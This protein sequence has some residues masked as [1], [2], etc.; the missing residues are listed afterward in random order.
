MGAS[1]RFDPQTE[2]NISLHALGEPWESFEMGRTVMGQPG[3]RMALARRESFSH[4]G[5]EGLRLFFRDEATGLEA[6]S[7]FLF[8]G[9]NPVS[10][11]RVTVR[12][13]GT[14]PIGLD[15]LHGAYIRNLEWRRPDQF[16]LH[17]PCNHSYAENQWRDYSLPDLGVVRTLR[18]RASHH[19]V[20][21]LGRS[22]QVRVPM[23]LLEDRLRG[24]TWVWQIEHPGA[25]L[26]EVGEED[27]SLS[28]ALGGLDEAHLH[29]FKTLQPGEE[30]ESLSVAAGAV[31]GDAERALDALVDFR[32]AACRSPHPV[33][34]GLPVVFNDYMNCLMGHVT[35]EKSLRLIPRAAEA[36]CE[37]YT[38]D[39]GWFGARGWNDVG[40]WH[41]NPG[42]FPGGLNRVMD[43]I[44]ER[45]MIPGLWLEIEAAARHV[46]LAAKPD[47]W[48]IF[49]RG[50]RHAHGDR[51]ALDFRNA[52]VRC[53]AD[54]TVDRLVHA[55]DLGYLKMDYNLT[56]G[57]GP[58]TRTDSP[59]AGAVDHLRAV[60]DWFRGVRA[61][62]PRVIIENCASGGMRNDYGMLSILQM[63]S[64]SDQ[65]DRKAYPPLVVG[66]LATLLPEQLGVWSY[67][68]AGEDREAA[69]FNMV[70]AMLGRIHQSGQIADID[71]SQFEAVREGIALYKSSLRRDI[72]RSHPFW[73]LG[74]V[75]CDQTES[76]QAAG[77]A[78]A[79]D[80]RAWL[81]VW[82]MAGPEAE[83][84]LPLERLPF[85]PSSVEQV[86]PASPRRPHLL[87]SG[88]LRATLPACHSAVL[89]G[90][91][92]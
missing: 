82:R 72:P 10:R 52:E 84:E 29:W 83:I 31:P 59:G 78:T 63:A 92:A 87:R 69:V 39:A 67:P 89:F 14:Q 49:R 40:D 88:V 47:D 45:G 19:L 20:S 6:T 26:W 36:G 27:D 91:R 50:Q 15:T 35:E 90:V 11:R 33:D 42:K 58:D 37:V 21:A 86:Y 70:N 44:R 77:L 57:L 17:I 65:I 71:A 12:N 28:L 66:G 79:A 8:F 24:R 62:H 53:F 4:G 51:F 85:R 5:G 81:A 56:I 1:T 48:F 68:K 74:R 64:S 3:E 25:W 7:E 9:D 60:Q 2:G 80:R 46:A 43:A 22:S 76:F 13:G 16:R 32:R 18:R 73:P 75:P 38:V 61:R 55:H 30:C 23:A 34:D 54:E 41:E